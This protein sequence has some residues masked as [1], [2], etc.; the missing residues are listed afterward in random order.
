[1][2]SVKSCD[3]NEFKRYLRIVLWS[4]QL[5]QSKSDP[6]ASSWS[7]AIDNAD[8]W[9]WQPEQP[10]QDA[11]GHSWIEMESQRKILHTCHNKKGSEG[12]VQQ[13]THLGTIERQSE[14]GIVGNVSRFRLHGDPISTRDVHGSTLLVRN[15]ICKVYT[16]E[17]NSLEFPL[18]Y[19]FPHYC[20][21][22]FLLYNT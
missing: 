17:Q 15:G 14:Q 9:H 10:I 5:P 3:Y 22:C 2:E 4:R 1:M 20:M 8:V 7:S 13:Q 6:L 19:T 12:C 18:L 21:R 11:D 16:G